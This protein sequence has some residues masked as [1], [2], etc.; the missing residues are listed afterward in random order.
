VTLFYF[1]I[2]KIQEIQSITYTQINSYLLLFGWKFVDENLSEKSLAD[3]EFC[4]IDPRAS[5]NSSLNRA[6]TNGGGDDNGN[7]S[8]PPPQHKR[9]VSGLLVPEGVAD[10]VRESSQVSHCKY[11]Y[12]ET[13]SQIRAWSFFKRLPGLGSEPGI[14]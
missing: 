6:V 9:S 12:G 13:P 1:K 14:F 10:F 5:S 3:L 7:D 8:H 11:F 2:T 4:K